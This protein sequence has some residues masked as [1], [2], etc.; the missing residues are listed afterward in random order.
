MDCIKPSFHCFVCSLV[1]VF[2]WPYNVVH[3]NSCLLHPGRGAEYC[4]QFVCLSVCVLSVHEHISGTAWPIFTKFGVQIPRGLDLVLLWRR[5]ATLCTF[6]FMDD[7]TFGNIGPYG[8]TWLAA[9]R[10]RGRFWCLW[11]F[12]LT[13][14]LSPFLNDCPSQFHFFL[15]W[16][17]TSLWKLLLIFFYCWLA[18]VCLQSFVDTNWQRVYHF[19]V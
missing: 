16:F 9:L 19:S 1:P 17:S 10:Y 13:L 12:C 2:L 8:D 3:W 6:G 18:S 5:C 7:V 4:D 15:S 14:L 11:M